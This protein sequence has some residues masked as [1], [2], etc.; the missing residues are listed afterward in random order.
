MFSE[1]GFQTT[2]EMYGKKLDGDNNNNL[3]VN[4]TCCENVKEKEIIKS[5]MHEIHLRLKNILWICVLVIAFHIVVILSLSGL[6]MPPNTLES[7]DGDGGVVVLLQDGANSVD[8]Y[9]SPQENHHLKRN[10]LDHSTNKKD[11]HSD[12]V[13]AKNKLSK[14]LEHGD[15]NKN[16]QIQIDEEVIDA[17]LD[18]EK[19]LQRHRD[20]DNNGLCQNGHAQ[21]IIATCEAVGCL[22]KLNLPSPNAE[23]NNVL[24]RIS[25]DFVLEM[26]KVKGRVHRIHIDIVSFLTSIQWHN[27]IFGS[28]AVLGDT[29]GFM[30]K[31]LAANADIVEGENVIIVP[32]KSSNE[33]FLLRQ[34]SFSDET[35]R[36]NIHLCSGYSNFSK[37]FFV[38]KDIPQFRFVS[39]NLEDNFGVLPHLIE[40]TS[41]IIREGGIL[42][43]DNSQ[44]DKVTENVRT[45][46][47]RHGN[48]AIIPLLATG[49]KLYFSSPRWKALYT[50]KLLQSQT[51]LSNFYMSY[52]NV[53]NSA[54]S[55][56]ISAG[57]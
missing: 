50:D 32:S 30:T 22:R 53:F 41:C 34:N 16:E 36:Q 21:D 57:S 6:N 33:N 7:Q 45:Y 39:I 10:I 49:N 5:E 28:V 4:T 35:V 23:T 8:S 46:F 25:R 20:M 3:T 54:C 27:G 11:V 12:F 47:A 13:T 37:V 1:F 31:L 14:G 29:F 43:L 2:R 15:H 51:M 52:D 48:S 56:L 38:E 9:V 44:T 26:R 42:V 40:M 17:N 24:N 19:V 55:Y 18:T